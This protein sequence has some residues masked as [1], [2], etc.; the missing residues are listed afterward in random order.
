MAAGVDASSA[1]ETTQGCINL[2][3]TSSS[4]ML[5]VDPRAVRYVLWKKSYHNISEAGAPVN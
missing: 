4:S 3:T 2:A 1:I 5:R